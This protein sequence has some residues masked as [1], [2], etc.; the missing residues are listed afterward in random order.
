TSIAAHAFCTGCEASAESPSMVMIRSLA[1]TSPTRMEQERCTSSLMCTE[2]APH[3]AIPQPY[4]VPVRPTCS[5]MTHNSGV[6]GSTSTSHTVPL[7]LSF[8]MSILSRVRSIVLL[9]LYRGAG[10]R[11]KEL[12]TPARRAQHSARAPAC[13][14]VWRIM[15]LALAAGQDFAGEDVAA[16]V[17][18]A[19]LFPGCG[20]EPLRRGLHCVEEC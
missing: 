2:Q 20:C 14:S 12:K 6:S 4:F 9:L 18:F 8:A 13:L 7:M 5:R 11:P 16:V 1:C 10:R 3:W 19:T 15:R 17:H